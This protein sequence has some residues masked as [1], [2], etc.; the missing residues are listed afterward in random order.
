[1]AASLP[2]SEYYKILPK[3]VDNFNPENTST[4][5]YYYFMLSTD[6]YKH[7]EVKWA[8][9]DLPMNIKQEIIKKK[10]KWVKVGY[11]L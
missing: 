11:Q 10:F 3:E 7:D 6:Y 9:D 4:D 5:G 8:T 2:I 1:M